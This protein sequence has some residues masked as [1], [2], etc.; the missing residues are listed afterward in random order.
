MM[1]TKLQE[2]TSRS[3]PEHSHCRGETYDDLIRVLSIPYDGWLSEPTT[4]AVDVHYGTGTAQNVNRVYVTDA[5]A[6]ATRVF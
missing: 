6:V 1:M 3:N 5:N 2:Y 4:S